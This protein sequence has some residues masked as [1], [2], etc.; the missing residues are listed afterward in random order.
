MERPNSPRA[1]SPEAEAG[2]SSPSLHQ[3]GSLSQETSPK[4]AEPHVSGADVWIHSTPPPEEAP[5]QHPLL[6]HAVLEVRGRTFLEFVL[7]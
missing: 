6:E 3:D 2:P 7:P 5:V 4:K 1:G